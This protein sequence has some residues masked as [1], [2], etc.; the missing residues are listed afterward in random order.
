[1]TKR[2]PFEQLPGQIDLEEAIAAKVAEIPGHEE[3]WAKSKIVEQI[4]HWDE[5][6]C[7]RAARDAEARKG[8]PLLEERGKTHGS[9][10]QNA[11]AFMAML[12]VHVEHGLF[13]LP[14]E[15]AATIV[16]EDLKNSRILGGSSRVREHTRDK[17]GYN[18]LNIPHTDDDGK[19]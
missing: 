12:K 13:D 4:P 6:T 19:D 16:M 9:W 3:S 10:P 2:A 8:K 15:F 14:D 17:I 11:R 18:Q 5:A 1:M 7:E